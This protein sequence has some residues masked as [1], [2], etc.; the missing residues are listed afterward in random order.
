L[1]NKIFKEHKVDHSKFLCTKIQF[2]Q[3]IP[4][5]REAEEISIEEAETEEAVETSLL[6]N[7]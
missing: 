4:W 2:V 7:C 5:S 3:S 6:S 1:K